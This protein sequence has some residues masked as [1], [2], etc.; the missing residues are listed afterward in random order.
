MIKIPDSL[1]EA[2]IVWILKPDKCKI[3]NYKPIPLVNI[4]TKK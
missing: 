2:N 1:Y 4:D 3:S